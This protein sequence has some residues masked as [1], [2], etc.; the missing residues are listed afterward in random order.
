MNE[1]IGPIYYTFATDPNL[2]W[3]GSEEKFMWKGIICQGY[4]GREE[5]IQGSEQ[6]R[7]LNYQRWNWSGFLTTTTGQ[8]GLVSK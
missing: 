2:E 1:I 7:R 4:P 5:K 8:T 6:V 3:R